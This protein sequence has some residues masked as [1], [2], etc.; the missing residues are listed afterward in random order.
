MRGFGGGGLYGAYVLWTGSGSG[1]GEG[2]S[3]R[4]IAPIRCLWVLTAA[5]TGGVGA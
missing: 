5:P 4:C 2:R 1:G 3:V